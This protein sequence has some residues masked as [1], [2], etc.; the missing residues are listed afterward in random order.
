[1]FK[2]HPD[3]RLSLWSDLRQSLNQS[4]NPLSDVARFWKEAPQVAYN[5]NIDQYNTRSWP[6]PWEII[7]EGKYD[8]FTVA[9]MMGW[10]LLLTD[11]F[12]DSKIEIRS[13]VDIDNNRLYNIVYV[14]DTWVLNFIDGEAATADKV[15]GL[16]RLENL[17]PLERP[18]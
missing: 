17:V 6:T 12:K 9:L 3:Q 10:T 18:R 11:K 14:D 13:L 16:Y 1:M 15:P 8:D 2:T 5:S 7:Y 4:D